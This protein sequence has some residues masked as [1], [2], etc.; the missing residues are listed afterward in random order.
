MPGAAPARVTSPRGG[1]A[2]A[3]FQGVSSRRTSLRKASGFLLVRRRVRI[4]EI[5]ATDAIP[6]MGRDSFFSVCLIRRRGNCGRVAMIL[7][8]AANSRMCLRFLD[9]QK[10]AFCAGYAR[11][12]DMD[13]NTDRV[14]WVERERNPSSGLEGCMRGFTSFNPSYALTASLTSCRGRA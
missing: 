11:A 1:T 14:R 3:P 6:L 7:L 8:C 13:R 10:V 2:L 4:Q 9:S 12:L 5:P